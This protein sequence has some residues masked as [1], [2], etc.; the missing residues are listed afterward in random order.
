[1]RLFRSALVLLG[2][3]MVPFL[4]FDTQAAEE[5]KAKTIA[6][7]VAMY[8]SSSCMECHTE[9]HEEW[10]QSLH[11]RSIFGP[12]NTGRTA[13]TFRTTIENGLKEWPHSGVKEAEDVGIKHLMICAKCHLPQ[14]EDAE[15]SVA[16]EIVENIYAYAEEGDEDA[17]ETLQSLN[18][19]C[20]ICHGRNA[21]VHK[22]KDGAPEKGV[23]YGNNDGEHE[24]ENFPKMKKSLIMKESILCGQCHGLGPNFDLENPTQCATLYGAHLFTYIPEGGTETCQECHMEKSKLGHNM[25]SYRSEELAKMALHVEVDAK[26]YQWR[27]IATMTPAANVIVELTNKAGHPIPDG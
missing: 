6:E 13:A 14:L 11:A 10:Q 18:I 16:K 5:K 21:I 15:E 17:A 9:I 2:M 7:L 27:D 20:T 26:A 12:E 4:A 23:V 3:A 1:M 8:D 19:G 22:W 25:Q 24:D